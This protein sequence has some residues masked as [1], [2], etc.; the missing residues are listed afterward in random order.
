VLPLWRGEPFEDA[1]DALWA[2]TERTRLR[3]QFVAAA[4]RAGELLLVAPDV[5]AGRLA[6]E[7]A[8]RA[9]PTFEPAYRLLARAH[10]A[11]RDRAGARA[12]LDRCEA[13]LRDL[14]V[15]PDEETT[16]LQASLTNREGA[17]RR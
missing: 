11:G 1:S 10:L 3:N 4:V 14:A 15:T 2:E 16:R 12:A 9:D 13:V 5:H 6:A 17:P 8:I 7:R